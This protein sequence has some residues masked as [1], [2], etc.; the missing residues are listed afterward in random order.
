MRNRLTTVT[1]ALAGAGLLAVSAAPAALA[2]RGDFDYHDG[3]GVAL[4]LHDPEN[5][6][7]YTLRGDGPTEN[8]TTRGAWLYEYPGCHGRPQVLAP[9]EGRTVWFNSVAFGD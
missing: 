6:R 2:A 8:N 9:R 4:S 5:G 7:C 1:A 3:N